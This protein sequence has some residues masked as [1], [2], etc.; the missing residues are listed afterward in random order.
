[1]IDDIL[2][3][4]F[5]L[6]ALAF[7]FGSF[8][9]GFNEFNNFA[10]NESLAPENI[11]GVIQAQND[12]WTSQLDYTFLFFYVGFIFVTIAIAW[13][14][15][16]NPLYF[17]LFGIIIFFIALISMYL[18]NIYYDF[19]QD[20]IFSATFNQMPIMTHILSNYLLYAIIPVMLMTI[21]FFMKPTDG[22]LG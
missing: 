11:K 22:G 2:L 3:Y 5:G 21:V 9:Y 19:T 8:I 10:Q 7:L 12:A 16:S 6:F 1:M 14:I 20:G 18:A 13:F 4:V 15:P 17:L